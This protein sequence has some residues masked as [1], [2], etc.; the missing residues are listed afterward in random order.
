MGGN[1]AWTMRLTDG[2]QYRMDRW[3]NSMPALICTPAFLDGTPEGIAQALDEW[4]RMQADWDANQHTEAYQYPMTPAYAPY[5]YGLQPSE[6]GLVVTDFVSKTILSLQGYTHLDQTM[7]S[8]QTHGMAVKNV[9]PSRWEQAEDLAKSG[10]ILGWNFWVDGD[11]AAEALVAI[12]G[13]AV[14]DNQA[15]SN[16][17]R[18]NVEIPGSVN[19]DTL[20]ACCDALRAP[21]GPKPHQKELEAARALLATT[22]NPETRDKL[23]RLILT[24]EFQQQQGPNPFLMGHARV[25]LAPFTFEEFSEDADGYE[26]LR[27]RILDLGFVLSEDEEKVWSERIARM[28]DHDD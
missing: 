8:R 14:K 12:G 11:A 17:Q 22:T 16:N 1:L 13:R 24:I 6:Y 3:T 19:V 10:R 9:S 28:R 20:N 4:Q 27:A 7:A 2:T 21:K 25:D 23:N 5:P 15:I 26:A 18:W